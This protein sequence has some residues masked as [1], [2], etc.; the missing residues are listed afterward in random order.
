[1]SSNGTINV[2][3][4][5]APKKN[6]NK[7][8]GCFTSLC[9]GEDNLMQD[10]KN[11]SE[12][13]PNPNIKSTFS[14]YH[15]EDN[16]NKDLNLFIEKYKTKIKIEKINF[17]Q[18][19]NIFMNYKYNFTKSDFILY[20]TRDD[21]KEKNQT[22]F[23]KQFPKINYNIKELEN[24]SKNRIE[25]LFRF[26]H[27]K[28]II[29][30][31]KDSKE[32]NSFDIIEKFL[33]FFFANSNKYKIDTLYILN[34]YITKNE[35]QE[36]SKENNNNENNNNENKIKLTYSEY[37]NYYIDE[38]LLYDY[39]PKILIDSSDIK[40]ANLNYNKEIV[41]NSYIFFDMFIHHENKEFN[42]KK[43]LIKISSKFEVNYLSDKN[44]EETDIFL[45]FI[46]KF[47][48]IY[49]IN[50]ILIEEVDYN[51]NKK[52]STYIWHC[53]SKRNKAL[54]EDKKSLIKQK[55]ILIPKKMEFNEYYKIIRNDFISILEEVKEEIISNNCVLF[56][57]D[58]Q[59][60]YIFLMKFIYIIIFKVTGLSFDNIYEYLKIKFVDL[61]KESLIKDKKLEF[62]NILI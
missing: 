17:V 47:N 52:T 58:E 4:Y 45:N 51:I 31:L 34:Q 41:N 32:E 7:S 21:L 61:S 44:T 46:Y 53:E 28:K 23:L 3:R 35:E 12:I 39:S 54:N 22:Q 16:L 9:K 38:D 24:F 6:G 2:Q 13:V 26:I 8:I 62:L 49:I 56:Q 59:I 20:D 18:I 25:K 60:E 29:F 30:I 36:I 27:D 42:N 11:S 1:M 50:F 5:N 19:F 14:S 55:N 57:F 33:I 10:N 43:P 37:L 48:I 40:S 15:N